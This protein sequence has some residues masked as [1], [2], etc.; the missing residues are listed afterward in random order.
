MRKRIAIVGAIIGTTA[1]IGIGRRSAPGGHGA[2]IPS[3]RPSRSRATTSS[4]SRVPSRPARSPSTRRRRPSGRGSSRWATVG[5]AGTATTSST[6]V[7]RARRRSCPNTRPSRSATSSRR[8]RRPGSSFARSSR[9]APSS[10]S[11]TRPWSRARR[12]RP[13]KPSRSASDQCPPASPP[14]AH[15]S[16]GRRRSS[17]PAGPSS[18][19][20][21]D[22]GR[23]RLIERFRVRFDGAGAGVPPDRPDH[24]LRRLRHGPP[25]AARHPRAGRADGGRTARSS[26][27]RSDRPRSNRLRPPRPADRSSSR[28]RRDRRR[29]SLIA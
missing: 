29:R 15:S 28:P 21:L 18:L 6:C 23:T 3:R 2:S 16:A 13:R 27:P 14:R 26:G 5:A 8:R 12:Q 19:E 20:P 24:G 4:R 10:C 7:A 1:G 25:P 17:P 11:A 22:D 9:A